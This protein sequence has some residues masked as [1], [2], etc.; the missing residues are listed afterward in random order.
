MSC[1]LEKLFSR[2]HF[3]L[4]LFIFSTVS[5]GR[6]YNKSSVYGSLTM[7]VDR[8]V[9]TGKDDVKFILSF[10]NDDT[11]TSVLL[12]NFELRLDVINGS[13]TYMD[14]QNNHI[15]SNTVSTLTQRLSHFF[16]FSQLTSTGGENQK[17]NIEFAIQPDTDRV[18]VTVRLELVKINDSQTEVLGVPILVVWNRSESEIQ[19][20]LEGISD[21][22]MFSANN[23][24]KFRI[25]NSGIDEINTED[26][27]IKIISG[28][29]EQLGATFSLN[30][31]VVNEQG[32][33]FRDILQDDVV[34]IS[35]YIS[36]VPLTLALAKDNNKHKSKLTL[37]LT[38]GAKVISKILTW[39]KVQPP[40]YS[41]E[42]GNK[43]EQ[44]G[45]KKEVLKT[46][47]EGVQEEKGESNKGKQ[48]STK[49]LKGEKAKKD[50]KKRKQQEKKTN[51]RKEERQDKQQQLE[52]RQVIAAAEKDLNTTVLL[53]KKAQKK[54]D[55]AKNNLIAKKKALDILEENKKKSEDTKHIT[56]TTKTSRT[57]KR[58]LEREQV[59]LENAQ[60]AIRKAREEF[61]VAKQIYISELEILQQVENKTRE[62]QELLK[63]VKQ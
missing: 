50:K 12:E 57:N 44:Q 53:Q 51:R 58:K 19:L 26:I 43:H 52:K 49:S 47:T 54:A 48:K 15:K 22:D 39:N 59:K 20:N 36:I 28:D 9:L 31:V 18:Q 34:K 17:A 40:S 38:C 11:N 46:K 61:E 33:R 16:N 37:E 29:E 4:L 41:D 42:E 7:H 25:I 23:K 56:Q 13:I 27:F 24:V 30:S 35:K 10:A 55:K 1:L 45:K 5:C 6:S 2:V 3:V 21:G 62:A 14:Y 32:K 60:E 63:K 8:P